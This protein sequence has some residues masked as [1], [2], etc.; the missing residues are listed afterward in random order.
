MLETV[1][2][3][4]VL[5]A[6]AKKAFDSFTSKAVGQISDAALKKLKGD[7]AHR[8]FERALGEAVQR[9]ATSSDFSWLVLSSKSPAS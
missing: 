9:Y 1:A 2:V 4:A 3:S 6:V 7:P 8:A 5:G